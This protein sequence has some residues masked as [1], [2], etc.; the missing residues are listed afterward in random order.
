M[1]VHF[2][3]ILVSGLVRRDSYYPE[4]YSSLFVPYEKFSER[5]MRLMLQ[6]NTPLRGRVP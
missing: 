3:D 5:I 4:R 6:W 2:R 1:R